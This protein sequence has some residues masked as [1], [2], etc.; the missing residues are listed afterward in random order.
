MSLELQYLVVMEIWNWTTSFFA[1][2]PNYF[3]DV[4]CAY[5][6]KLKPG[7]DW[8]ELLEKCPLQT[9]V[10]TLHVSQNVL[11]LCGGT[12]DTKDATPR[13]WAWSHGKTPG[14]ES[15]RYWLRETRTV[16]QDH[17]TGI[18]ESSWRKPRY[19]NEQW[20]W[21]SVKNVKNTYNFSLSAI[22]DFSNCVLTCKYM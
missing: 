1:T 20:E 21:A 10:T 16:Y 2:R 19:M 8:K 18:R 17:S 11:N 9:R 15:K 12:I 6:W 14:G 22:D 7:D 5:I 4:L 3:N 13:L